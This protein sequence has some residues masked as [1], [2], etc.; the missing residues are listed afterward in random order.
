[1]IIGN[2]MGGVY[3]TPGG[4]VSN[5]DDLGLLPGT[6]CCAPAFF[7]PRWIGKC[8]RGIPVSKPVSVL[9]IGEDIQESFF[10]CI[11]SVL[12]LG[13]INFTDADG[14]ARLTAEDEALR[15]QSH[16]L[17]PAGQS[18]LIFS[19]FGMVLNVEEDKLDKSPLSDRP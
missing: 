8:Y 4:Y 14:E 10:S 16:K 3:A 7:I 11:L 9:N 19:P 13:N 5:D 1:M 12:H 17:A 15:V 6:Q 18:V 2:F